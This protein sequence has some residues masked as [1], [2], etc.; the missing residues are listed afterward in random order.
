MMT[1]VQKIKHAIIRRAAAYSGDTLLGV[2]ITSDTVDVLYENLRG[3]DGWSDSMQEACNE[4]RGSFDCE[5]NLS[6]PC[7]RHYETK[8]VAKMMEDGTW[9]GW[10]YYY[11]GGKWG[12]PEEVEWIRDAYDLDVTEEQVMQTVRTFKKREAA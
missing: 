12:C 3:D 1:P 4:I 8:A 11:G 2:E 5:T 10:T 9:V 6:T 7:S